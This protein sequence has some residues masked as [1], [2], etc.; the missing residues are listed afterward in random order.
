MSE[1]LDQFHARVGRRAKPLPLWGSALLFLGVFFVLQMSYD[2]SR[3][4]SFEHFVIGDLTVVPTAAVINT[5][6][7]EVGVKALGNQLRAPGGGITVLKGCEGVEVMFMLAAAFAAVA[8][9]WRRRFTG[10]GLGLLLV[11][12]L[13]QCRLVG[14]FYAYRSDPSL[15]NLLHGFL[16]PIAMVIVVALFA[17]FWLQAERGSTSAN[18]APGS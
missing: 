16:A 11:F 12:G 7:P 5:L 14:L 15:F 18:A 1:S 3:G 9:P 17:L 4:S 8:M 6:T 2:L 13:N 10:L